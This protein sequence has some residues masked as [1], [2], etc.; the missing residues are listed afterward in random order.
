MKWFTSILKFCK[1]PV[2]TPKNLENSAINS[3]QLSTV[4]RSHED[5][6]NTS[7]YALIVRWNLKPE[8]GFMPVAALVADPGITLNISYS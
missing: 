2:A 7:M 1:N 3:V 8:N 6:I 5:L 4:N